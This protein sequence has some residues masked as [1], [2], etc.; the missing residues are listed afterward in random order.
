MSSRELLKHVQA[1]DPVEREA[2]VDAVVSMESQS[3]ARRRKKTKRVKWPDV[4]HRARRILGGKIVPNLVLLER[5]EEG[6]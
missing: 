2:F 4:E 1:L 3:A 6:H 5:E